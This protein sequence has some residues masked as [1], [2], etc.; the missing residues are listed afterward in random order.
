M[1]SI[2]VLEPEGPPPKTLALPSSR[3]R[4]RIP[5]KSVPLDKP[6][7]KVQ[8]L[9]AKKAKALADRVAKKELKA[10]RRVPPRN[11]RYC[12]LCD[13]SCNSAQTFYDHINSKGHRTREK[14]KKKTPRCTACDRVFDSHEV[15]K[16]HENGKEHLKVVLSQRI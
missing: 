9:S 3:E 2:E 4:Y 6:I 16:R 5:R 11:K 13:I 14:N 10:K 1:E 7:K 15:L 8:R 12:K